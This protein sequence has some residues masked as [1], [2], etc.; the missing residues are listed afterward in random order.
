MLTATIDDVVTRLANTTPYAD[1]DVVGGE[2]LV[3]DKLPPFFNQGCL[4]ESAV[5]LSSAFVSP[6]PDLRLFLFSADITG[7]AADNVAFAP[8][9]EQ[10]ATLIGVITFDTDNWIG[11]DQTPGAG[12]NMACVESN[13]GIVHKGNTLYGVLVVKNAYVPV[14]SE[15]FTVRLSVIR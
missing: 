9:D 13:L 2:T 15:V 6:A 5:C 14:A 8:T 3:F 12:G 11:G 1:G 10:M 4:I 7:L